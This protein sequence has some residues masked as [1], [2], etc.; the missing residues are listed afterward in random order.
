[1]RAL[2][3]VN[4]LVALL[5]ANHQ[6]HQTAL[7]WFALNAGGGW[8]SCPITQNGCL[9]ILSLPTYPNARPIADIASRLRDMT[10]SPVHEFWPDDISLLDVSRMDA[11]RVHGARQL[12]DVYL[13]ALAVHRHGA[14]VT[15][16]Q[17]IVRSA[18]RG[19]ADAHLIHL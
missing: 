1:V 15:F 3:D 18:V 2:L 19:A 13:L 8:A 7:S 11:S 17:R 9:R 12:T 10:D 5:D 14:L 6:A 16:D 4:V